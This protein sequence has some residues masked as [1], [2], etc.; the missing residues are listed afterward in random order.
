MKK[1][2]SINFKHLK[3]CNFTYF[4]HLHRAFDIG[5]RL[6]VASATCLI[7]AVL[8]FLFTESASDIMLKIQKRHENFPNT[9]KRLKKK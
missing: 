8:P 6:F 7:H 3:E 9:K 1:F 2:L 5:I 4:S